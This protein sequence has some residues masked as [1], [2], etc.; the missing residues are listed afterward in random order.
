MEVIACP[1]ICPTPSAMFPLSVVRGAVRE[2]RSNVWRRK[3]PR[4]VEST[5]N[6]DAVVAAR[7]PADDARGGRAISAT[8]G[9]WL[10]EHGFAIGANVHCGR[11]EPRDADL[12][13]RG[14][15][16]GV[17]GARRRNA[18]VLAGWIG[19]RSAAEWEARGRFVTSDI[20]GF[21]GSAA[22]RSRASRRD[23]SVPSRYGGCAKQARR[24]PHGRL[25][26]RPV[27]SERNGTPERL[28][29]DFA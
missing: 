27:L 26:V 20:R 2:N 16:G 11:T 3:E 4:T 25:A 14:M 10:E 28:G 21:A 15:T 12:P 17:V 7:P 1:D 9:R 8:V 19:A 18:G 29:I 23:A 22:R 13:R 6:A 24:A 5:A